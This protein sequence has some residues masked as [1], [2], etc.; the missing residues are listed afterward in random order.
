VAIPLW[1]ATAQ[2]L[3]TADVAANGRHI[4]QLMA[5]A[6]AAGA[7]LVHFPEGALSGNAKAQLS[8]WAAVDWSGL[9]QE[10]GAICA[11]ARELDI[12]VVLGCS[13]QLTPPNRPH[14]SLYVISATGDLTTRYD[15]RLCSHTEISDWYSAGSEPVVFDVDGVRFGCA[16]CI[17][18]QFPELFAQNAALGVECM[19]LSAYAR[20]PIF[21]VLA[22]AHAATNNVW[23]S[24]ATPAQCG[25]A[26]A[27]RFIGPDGNVLSGAP[28]RAEPCLIRGAID[29]DDPR[30]A[31]ALT[32]ARPWRQAAR[33]G[34]IYRSHAAGDP[35]SS[36]R[37]AP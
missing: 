28:E 6:R 29:R 4:R 7:R 14:N 24:L 17:E 13:H 3:I 25:A 36:N 26:L 1:I 23:L 19:L 33:Q 37:K 27:S 18:V 2:S 5:E 30:F 32:K 10:L 12:W 22:Q 15:K 16:L 34:D 35:R 21:A 8:H 9:R 31:I 11:A 20:D